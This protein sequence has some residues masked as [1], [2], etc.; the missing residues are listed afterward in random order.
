MGK[1]SKFLGGAL[2]GMVVGAAVTLLLA[3]DSGKG[4]R[5]QVQERIAYIQN[6]AR[7][8][9]EAQRAALEAEL[10]RLRGEQF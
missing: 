3:P 7:R 8:A 4:L 9:A 6:E 5:A 10:A 2:G 1:L